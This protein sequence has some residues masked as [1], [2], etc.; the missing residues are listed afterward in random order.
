MKSP[1]LGEI[2]LDIKGL[3][4]YFPVNRGL[5]TRKVAEVKAVDGV[6]FRIRK[7]ETLGLVGESGC[8]KTTLR[9]WIIMLY[10]PTAGQIMFE[11]QDIASASEN[12]IN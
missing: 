4:M 5:L 1:N 3:K 8:G 10:K 9:R 7:G 2:V 11:G 12:K 6:S